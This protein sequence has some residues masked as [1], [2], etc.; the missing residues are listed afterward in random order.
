MPEAKLDKSLND[1]FLLSC[2]KLNSLLSIFI[3]VT[4]SFSIKSRLNVT[5]NGFDIRLAAANG[6]VVAKD[7]GQVSV[8]TSAALTITS[9]ASPG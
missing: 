7:F 4:T 8:N 6:T 1:I 5:Y 9:L 3:L 2:V